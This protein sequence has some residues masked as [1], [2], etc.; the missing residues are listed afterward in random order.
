VLIV[1]SVI[2]FLMDSLTPTISFWFTAPLF[3]KNH[4]T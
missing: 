1:V 4:S 2:P 3:T